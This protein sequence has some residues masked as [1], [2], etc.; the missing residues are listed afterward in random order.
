MPSDV[1]G[2][3]AFLRDRIF[4]DEWV[5][6]GFLQVYQLHEHYLRGGQ[7]P[8]WQEGRAG[9]ELHE[10]QVQQVEPSGRLR[11]ILGG[12]DLI[13]DRAFVRHVVRQD[14]ARVLADVAVKRKILDTYALWLDEEREALGDYSSWLNGA[15]PVV[16]PVRTL[17]EQMGVGL[18]FALR[19]L[20][21]TYAGHPKF[22]EEWTA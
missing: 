17:P 15:A 6:L 13:G 10:L 4:E 1:A 12:L 19:L 7:P 22:R 14:P 11:V 9:F 8:R 21:V 3:I 5:A 2:L 18:E 20:A 16:K